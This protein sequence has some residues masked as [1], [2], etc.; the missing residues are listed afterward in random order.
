MRSD[1][2]RER[3]YGGPAGVA[4]VDAYLD[5]LVAAAPPLTAGQKTR[6]RA[7]LRPVSSEPAPAAIPHQRAA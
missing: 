7:L 6:L 3:L 2:E 5:A 1:A 4:R